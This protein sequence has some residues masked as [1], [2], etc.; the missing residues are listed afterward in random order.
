MRNQILQLRNLN[1]EVKQLRN[2]SLQLASQLEIK[3]KELTEK[4]SL[5][6]KMKKE[7]EK[8]KTEVKTLSDDNEKLKVEVV[9]QQETFEKSSKTKIA[10]LENEIRKRDVEIDEIKV[11][12]FFYSFYSFVFFNIIYS[13]SILF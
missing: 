12:S 8:I 2:D 3:D 4:T 10:R 11:C 5:V 9:T 7:S 6:T 13:F 1:K